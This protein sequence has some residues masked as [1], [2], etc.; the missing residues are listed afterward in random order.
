[1]IPKN[2]DFRHYISVAEFARRFAPSTDDYSKAVAFF[3][4]N[5][6]NV[7]RI[8]ANRLMIDVETSVADAERVFHV[9]LGL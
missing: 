5:G 4:S 6:M 2:P 7:Q 1:M 3:Q 9:T 8:S